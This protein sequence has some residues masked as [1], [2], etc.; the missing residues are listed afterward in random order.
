MEKTEKGWAERPFDRLKGLSACQLGIRRSAEPET[1]FKILEKQV[2]I[3]LSGFFP[4]VL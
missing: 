1:V 4:V 3:A 2:C